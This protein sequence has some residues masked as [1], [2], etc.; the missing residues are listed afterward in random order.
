MTRVLI[1]GGLVAVVGAACS[2]PSDERPSAVETCG[3]GAPVTRLC[4]VVDAL[5]EAKDEARR[6]PDAARTIFFDRAHGPLHEIA[7]A[8]EVHR[9]S[10]GR[11]LEAKQAVEADLEAT[12]APELASESRAA[13]RCNQER[14]E[15]TVGLRSGMR[16][17]R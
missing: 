15:A 5:C 14:A 6:D 8:E 4:G 11:V 1:A 2:S 13:H 10:A 3:E 17:L 12:A 7:A 9:S 16:R